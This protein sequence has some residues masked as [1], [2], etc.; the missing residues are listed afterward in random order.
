M[1]KFCFQK[2]KKKKKSIKV[3]PS[4]V[5]VYNKKDVERIENTEN[6]NVNGEHTHGYFFQ[7][8]SL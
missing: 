6:T 4:D 2:K 1:S 7:T 3:K 8:P 5:P